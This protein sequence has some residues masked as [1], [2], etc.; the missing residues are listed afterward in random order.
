MNRIKYNLKAA[1]DNGGWLLALSLVS[2]A[3][4][5]FL[6]VLP[7]LGA[8]TTPISDDKT[9]RQVPS[10]GDTGFPVEFFCQDSDTKV[11]ALPAPDASGITYQL[12]RVKNGVTESVIY[13]TGPSDSSRVATHYFDQAG[14]Q[15][16]EPAFV[17][18]KAKDCIE[19][20]AQ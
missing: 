13:N 8:D 18:D 17:N 1:L 10:E 5:I 11:T 9:V 15:Q 3:L 19:R 7:G 20:R 12:V 4:I 14:Q 2:A 16:S 6:V